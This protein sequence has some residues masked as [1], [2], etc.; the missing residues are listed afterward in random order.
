MNNPLI[1]DQLAWDRFF[2]ES[3]KRETYPPKKI[4]LFNRLVAYTNNFFLI[5]ATGAFTP[6][7]LMLIT[8]KLIPSHSMIEEKHVD[9]LKWLIE[10]IS[11][12]I[13]KTYKKETVTFEHGNC[14]CLGGL[15]RAHLHIMTINEKADNDLITKCINKTLINR[16][17]GITSVEI[18]GSK[19]ENIHDISEIINSPESNFYKVNGKQLLYED[20]CNGFDINNWPISTKKHVQNNGQYVYFKTSSP[21]TSFLTDKNFQTQLGRQIVFEIEKETNSDIKNMSNEILKKN[22][23]ANIWKWQEFQFKENMFR[24]MNDLIP[25]LLDIKSNKFNFSTFEK[26]KY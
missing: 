4:D 20:I 6:G 17:A 14:A 26:N 2:D 7:Y 3:S 18:N 15:D 13:S 22:K 21:S 10:V 25:K 9:E 5:A 8:K 23:Y 24:T 11:K 12:A 16:K 1:K 19:L